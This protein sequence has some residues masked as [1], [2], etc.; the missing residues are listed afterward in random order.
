MAWGC[1]GGRLVA[2][3]AQGPVSCRTAARMELSKPEL[4]GNSHRLNMGPAREIA[5]QWETAG[6]LDGWNLESV[7]EVQVAAEV[8]E[9]DGDG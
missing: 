4:N 6:S 9:R 1:P 3:R 8:K 5:S 2:L 7:M